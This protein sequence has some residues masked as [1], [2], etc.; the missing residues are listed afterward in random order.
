MRVYIYMCVCVSQYTVYKYIIYKLLQAL[1]WGVY[2]AALGLEPCVGFRGL[3]GS[4]AQ[5]F[6]GM[7]WG[8]LELC[9]LFRR[10]RCSRSFHFGDQILKFGA[11][12]AGLSTGIVVGLVVDWDGSRL[13]ASTE[14]RIGIAP[15]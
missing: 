12:C 11:K 7:S 1:G 13:R 6:E 10:P 14:E 15:K 3:V 5:G 8:T 2:G 9:R 4:A